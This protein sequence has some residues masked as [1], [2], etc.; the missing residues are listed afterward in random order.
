MKRILTGKGERKAVFP[1]H[2][3]TKSPVHNIVSVFILQIGAKYSRCGICLYVN[4]PAKAAADVQRYRTD[5]PCGRGERRFVLINRQITPS[6][7]RRCR[8]SGQES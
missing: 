7:S 8:R 4:K 5:L 1:K 2:T 6:R 3:G